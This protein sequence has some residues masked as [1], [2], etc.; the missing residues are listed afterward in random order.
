MLTWMRLSW[1]FKHQ[2]YISITWHTL[3]NRLRCDGKCF[4][5][6][7]N[8][9]SAL[10]QGEHSTHEPVAR[11]LTCGSTDRTLIISFLH[12]SALFSTNK[13]QKNC[14]KKMYVS[15]KHNTKFNMWINAN[16]ITKPRLLIH[17]CLTPASFSVSLERGVA[18]LPYFLIYM[19][20]ND[21]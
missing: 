16:I 7:V 11:P 21:S 18:T 12:I 10:H 2:I 3:Y 5:K 20:G 17:K 1:F 6:P 13:T 14:K 15:I 4:L 8:A 19:S 9:R